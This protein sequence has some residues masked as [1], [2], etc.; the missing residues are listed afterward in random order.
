[1]LIIQHEISHAMSKP[2]LR[3]S[4]N[5]VETLSVLRTKTLRKKLWFC[6]LTYEERVLAGLIIKHIKIVKNT[7]LATVIARILGKLVH[8]IMHSFLN[9]IENLGR[10]VARTMVQG[11]YS[12]GN[13]DALTWVKDL[14][15]IRYLGFMAYYNPTR[16]FLITKGEG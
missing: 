11:A 6:T 4:C 13:K 14:D 10:A 1:M 7:I 16:R 15:Y 2:L 12:C 5:L 9:N 3:G 8:A